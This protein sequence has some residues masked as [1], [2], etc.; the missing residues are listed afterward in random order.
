MLSSVTLLISAVH[1]EDLGRSED[2]EA[3]HSKALAA[4][5]GC[6]VLNFMCKERHFPIFS[7][8]GAISGSNVA[9]LRCFQ[10]T[11][12]NNSCHKHCR[13]RTLV[14]AALKLLHA[15]LTSQPAVMCK[16]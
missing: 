6:S 16:D 9:T 10:A 13:Q 8:G 11:S 15:S 2:A 14:A 12:S 7:S 1:A 4:M 5:A 3:F